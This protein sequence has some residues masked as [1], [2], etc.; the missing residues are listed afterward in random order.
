MTWVLSFL[1]QVRFCSVVIAAA[2]VVLIALVWLFAYCCLYVEVLVKLIYYIFYIEITYLGDTRVKPADVSPSN[3]IDKDNN[4]NLSRIALAYV[5]QIVSNAIILGVAIGIL[6]NL[7]R[8]CSSVTTTDRKAHILGA[9]RVCTLC[10]S[11]T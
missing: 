7:R 2:A 6:E 5:H 3:N 1:P 11:N 9:L 8:S 10:R 4:G